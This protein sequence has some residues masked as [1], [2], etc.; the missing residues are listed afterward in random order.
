MESLQ[1]DEEKRGKRLEDAQ[2]KAREIA[3][4]KKALYDSLDAV[5]L[6]Q[7]DLGKKVSDLNKE[8]VSAVGVYFKRTIE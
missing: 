5:L 7:T 4:E 8:V 1:Q 6:C 3:V 2:A